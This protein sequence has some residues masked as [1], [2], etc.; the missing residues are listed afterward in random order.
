MYATEISGR[1]GKDDY[2]IPFFW[3][4]KGCCKNLEHES[5][6][7]KRCCVSKED[8]FGI[9]TTVAA[10]SEAFKGDIQLILSLVLACDYWGCASLV[11]S[12]HEQPG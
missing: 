5:S 1:L 3:G 10:S 8:V 9:V 2:G 12:M 7:P 6:P 11:M 4:C